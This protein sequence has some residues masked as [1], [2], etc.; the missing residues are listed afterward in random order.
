MRKFNIAAFIL[1]LSICFVSCKPDDDKPAP[2]PRDRAEVYAEDIDAIE[3]YLQT[4]YMVVD[5]DYNVQIFEIPEGGTQVSIWDQTEFPLAYDLVKTDNRQSF[6]VD[7]KFDDPVEYKLYYIIFNQGGGERPTTVDSTFV[8]YRG[9]KLDNLQFDVSPNPIWFTFEETAVSGFRQFSAK[10]NA[11]ENFTMNND[12]TATFNNYGAGVVFIPSGLAYFERAPSGI[13]AY[14]PIVFQIHLMGLKY[15]D[16]DRDGILSR[17]EVY[18]G[19]TSPFDQ[20]S[21]GDNIP[22]FYDVDDDGDGRLTRNEIKDSEG[23]IIPFELIPDCNG[24]TTNP[25]RLKKHLDPS[26]W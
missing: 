25:E 11:A 10:L 20:D 8:S 22:D 23:N 7:G 15:R 26:C 17:D 19:N 2:P 14:N 13:G 4:H 9:W 12:G 21:D 5:A 24:N 6:F 16:H 3:T 18:N 1:L